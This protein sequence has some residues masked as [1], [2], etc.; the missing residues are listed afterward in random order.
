MNDET[1]KQPIVTPPQQ[2]ADSRLSRA[3]AAL[4]VASILLLAVSIL[5]RLLFGSNRIGLTGYG[6]GLFQHGFS[7]ALATELDFGNMSPLMKLALLL[8]L[9]AFIPGV[10]ALFCKGRKRLAMVGIVT[11]GLVV[12]F[13][14]LLQLL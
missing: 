1:P 11:G 13:P 6:E 4:G 8:G 9:I 5:L 14:F 3:S 7:P 2:E 10:A 12:L